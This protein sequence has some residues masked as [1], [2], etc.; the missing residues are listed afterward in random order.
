[1]VKSERKEGVEDKIGKALKIVGNISERYINAS[2]IDKRAIV[3]LIYPE[4]IIFDGSDFQTSKINSFVD[5]IFLIR[6]EL[7]KQKKG[8]LNSKNLNPRLV[9]S[10]GFKPVTF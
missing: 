3:S 8:D 5:N 6:R 1:M 2:P 7:S 9:T 4:K 10:T